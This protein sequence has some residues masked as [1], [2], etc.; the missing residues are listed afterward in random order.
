MARK[1]VP[2]AAQLKLLRECVANKGAVMQRGHSLNTVT[3]CVDRQW[4]T[5]RG[6][7]YADDDNFIKITDMGRATVSLRDAV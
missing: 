3:A 7:E 2:T 6:R 5:F 1:F 4:V